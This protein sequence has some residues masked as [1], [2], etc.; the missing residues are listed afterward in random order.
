[1]RLRV[2][3]YHRRPEGAHS[4]ERLF[5]DVR[6]SLPEGI[7]ATVAVSRFASKGLFRRIYNTIDA[8]FRQGNVNHITGDV[9]FL[10]LLLRKKKTLLT[11]ADL[12]SVH[13][14]KGWRRFVFL[15]F[16]YRLPIRR[17]AVVSVISEA[18]K[19]DLRRHVTVDPGKVRVVPC[20]V[21]DDFT[22]AA[23]EFNARKP[24]VLVVGTSP[25][26]NIERIAQALQGISCHLR[27]IGNL[28]HRGLSALRQCGVEYSSVSS[29]TDAQVADEYRRCDMLVFASTYEGFG[30]PILEAQATGRPVVSSNVCSMPEVAG[31]AACLVDPFDVASIRGGILKVIDDAAYRDNLVKAG[32]ENV[33]RFRPGKIARQYAD[34]YHELCN[35]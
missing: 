17:A 19:E 33:E 1:M 10:A 31:D 3:F 6:R 5:A 8:A 12:V 9:H 18:T 15:L 7:N 14:L 2:T 34:I 21:S 35:T 27:V 16:W 28:D 25:N 24:V 20:C 13:R 4:I 30:L 32:F 29:I 26:K 22:P 23:K 11:I